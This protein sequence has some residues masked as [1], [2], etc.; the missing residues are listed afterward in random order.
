MLLSLVMSLQHVCLEIKL[1]F[2]DELVTDT[3]LSDW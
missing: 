2:I 1:R 3:R